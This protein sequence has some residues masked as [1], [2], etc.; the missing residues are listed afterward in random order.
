M[1]FLM[2]LGY[3]HSREEMIMK[4][5]FF[6]IDGTLKP[7]NENELRDS[8]IDMLKQLRDKG[9]KV[10]LASGRPPVQ[11]PLLG[12]KLNAFHWDGY[13]L[14]N[15]Q[16]VM[17][18]DRNCIYKLPIPTE[19]LKQLVPWLKEHADYPC[20]FMEEDYSYDIT[21]NE[22]HYNYLKSIGQEDKMPKI[23]DPERS[24]T[25]DTYQICPYIKQEED[26]EW[27]SHAPGIKSARWTPAF[28]DMIPENGGKPVGIQVMLDKIGVDV[29]DCIAFG[30][31]GND[32]TMLEYAGIGVAMGNAN[33][34]VKSH[35]DYVTDDCDKDGLRKAFEHFGIL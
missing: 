22:E 8:T 6:D 35:A 4:A 12:E 16:Y 18:E 33:D 17:D 5:A 30:D 7:F 25:H 27:V 13:I 3:N 2:L 31:G 26:D 10:F 11:L 23:D 21:F 28:A 15:G 24:Y 34:E 1:G 9:I 29:K 32:I 20:P 19:A 14:L